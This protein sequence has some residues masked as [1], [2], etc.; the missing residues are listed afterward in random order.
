ME[1]FAKN[2]ADDIPSIPIV[3]FDL[4][5][6]IVAKHTD[7][8]WARFIA[9][10]HPLEFIGMRRYYNFYSLYKKGRL[11][12]GDLAEF[13]VFRAQ[14]Y[15]VSS[16]CMLAGEFYKKLGKRFVYPDAVERIR[17]HIEASSKVVLITAQHDLVAEPFARDLGMEL[18]ANRF[19]IE[20]DRFTGK[21]ILPYCYREGKIHHAEKFAKDRGFELNDCGF[22]T[23]SSNDIF[24][25][26]AVGH[27]FAVN[28]DTE[29]EK[30]AREKNWPILEWKLL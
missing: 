4:D 14:K 15:T 9:L 22:Y 27:P 7:G 6:T 17:A 18:I 5:E 2:S 3:F 13:Y 1:S 26:D 8:L 21:H 10:K 20:G 11:E 29:L 28:P 12:A 19:E 23:D 25:L 16:F 30:Y 24:M